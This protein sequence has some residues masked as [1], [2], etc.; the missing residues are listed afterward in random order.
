MYDGV[1]VRATGLSLRGEHGWAYRDVTVA[2][3]PGSLTAVTGQAGSG[4]TSLLLTLAGRMKPTSGTLTV[5]GAT[6]PRVIRRLAALGLVDGVNDLDAALSVREHVRE[7]TPSPPWNRHRSERAEAAFALADL[8]LSPGDRTLARHLGRERR[9]R[10]GIAL[11]LLDRPGLLVLDNVDTGLSRD[12]R[13]ALTATL[14]DLAGRGLTVVLSCIESDLPEQVRLPSP[15]AGPP[16]PTPD[17]E[18]PGPDADPPHS[19]PDAGP[20]LRV[21]GA[22]P[23]PPGPEET[24]PGHGADDRDGKRRDDRDEGGGR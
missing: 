1:E 14:R 22:R 18:P 11:A 3:A 16:H 21:P 17:T 24:E 13:A 6:T 4:R 23:G 12:R 15:D 20:P 7:R 10:L 2:A 19:S 5:G 9:I 8:D